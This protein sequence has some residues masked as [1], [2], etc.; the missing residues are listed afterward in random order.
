MP[1][2]A[3]SEV[4]AGAP[5]KPMRLLLVD[6][7]PAI[8]A[9]FTL[10]FEDQG[11]SVETAATGEEAI[12]RYETGAF[13]LIITDKNLPGMSGVDLIETIRNQDLDVTLMMLTG[14]GS[15]ESA[16]S[17]LNAGIDAY[18]EKPVRD[19]IRLTARAATI[20]RRR[21]KRRVNTPPPPEIPAARLDVLVMAGQEE[22]AARIAEQCS[23]GT[24]DTRVASS[25]EEALGELTSVDLILVEESTPDLIATIEAITDSR[26]DMPVAVMGNQLGLERLMQLVDLGV[27]AC[28]VLPIGSDAFATKLR[29]LTEE[30]RREKSAA[31]AEPTS[32]RPVPLSEG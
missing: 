19:V 9:S 27:V 31:L 14:F 23:Q 6:D 21:K 22:L 28:I 29:D 10:A 15:A 24:C 20:V 12:E 16:V 17:T 25:R 5:G 13:D 4:G 8:L 30:L 26:E 3:S 1:N 7:E 11:W 2:V 18:V 32:V